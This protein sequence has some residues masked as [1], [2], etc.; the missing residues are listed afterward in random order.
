MI[1]WLAGVIDPDSLGEIGMLLHNERRRA[2]LEPRRVSGALP[3]LV[4]KVNIATEGEKNAAQTLSRQRKLWSFYHVKNPDY[5]KFWLKTWEIW[6]KQWKWFRDVSYGFLTNYRN[7]D[8]CNLAYFLFVL[9]VCLSNHFIPLSL[10]FHFCYYTS[11]WKWT[12]QFS[13]L[14]DSYFWLCWVF[15]AALGL[16]LVL[17]RGYSLV[18]CV[19]LLLWLPSL[20]M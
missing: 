2:F 20:I 12:S 19:V 1:A 15:V 18:A 9:G 16:S 13:L 11:C 5:L 17:E 4:V 8:C 7:E 3:C 14:K 6:D 10:S